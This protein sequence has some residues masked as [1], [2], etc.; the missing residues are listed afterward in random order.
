MQ[1]LKKRKK[2]KMTLF[3]NTTVLTALVKMSVLFF[4]IFHFCRFWNFQF[5]ERCFLI[6]SQTSKNN[7]IPKQQTHQTTA[8]RKQDAKQ[9]QMKYYDSKQNK[10]TSRKKNKK[11][12]N[13]LQQKSKQNKK[14]TQAPDTEMRKEEREEQERYKE[15]ESEKGGGPKRLKRNS[16]RH[17][18]IHKNVLFRG[19]TVF[20]IKNKQ[21]KAK[22][23]TQKKK[24]IRRI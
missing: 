12:K 8:I 24:K 20:S 2:E 14:K 5:F 16:G 17:S 1:N 10:T 21:R 23:K 11:Q 3:V 15:R 19:K 18:K 9:N 6:G 13:I 7:K 4:C 22:E